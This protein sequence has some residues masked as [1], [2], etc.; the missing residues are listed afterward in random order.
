MF[1]VVLG[2]YAFSESGIVEI[3]IPDSVREICEK[4]FYLAKS[5]K[6]V[7]FGCSS[8]LEVIGEVGFCHSGLESI[9][10]PC[11][12]REIGCHS[13]AKLWRYCVEAIDED[14]CDE[15]PGKPGYKLQHPYL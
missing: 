14:E 13:F 6:S 7:T 8:H 5:L 1:A 9:D 3:S 15:N 10:L 12:V 4:C 11:T 2:S